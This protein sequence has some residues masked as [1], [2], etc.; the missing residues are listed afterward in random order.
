MKLFFAWI[1]LAGICFAQD[2]PNQSQ[3]LKSWREAVLLD[4]PGEIL[5]NEEQVLESLPH[6]SAL[7][8]VLDLR[9][10]ARLQGSR[11]QSARDLI[12]STKLEPSEAVHSDIALARVALF[13]D[14]LGEVQLLLKS[15]ETIEVATQF[16]DMPDAWLLLGRAQARSNQEAD[17]AHVLHEFIRRDP[18]HPEVPSAW[19]FLALD[20]RRTQK[21]LQAKQCTASADRTAKWHLYYRARLLQV[22]EN[23]RATLPRIGLVILWMQ[24]GKP[25]SAKDELQLIFEIDP[26]HC[27][28]LGH[29]AEAER[30]LG[31]HDAAKH[32]YDRAIK[33]APEQVGLRFNRAFLAT[34]QGRDADARSDYEWIL[35]SEHEADPRF[36]NA[37]FE[38]A[39]IL[40]KAEETEG[41]SRHYQ[42]YVELGGQVPL[43]K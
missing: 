43:T 15:K 23:P 20:A 10:R 6:L 22:R 36:L 5:R 25:Q 37:H 29:L 2:T 39:R 9:V 26:N 41:S 32:A 21:L 35:A 3:V 12:N 19:R 34:S 31:H 1:L 18:M 4:L 27:A 16:R 24:A 40:L 11:P 7:G 33:C 28:A 38:L 8:E 17:A 14:R 30:K 42:R 13:E